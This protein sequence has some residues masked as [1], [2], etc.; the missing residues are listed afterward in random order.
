M[1]GVWLTVGFGQ[2]QTLK[3]LI[4]NETVV[5]TDNVVHVDFGAMAMSQSA[6]QLAA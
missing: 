2:R 4:D 3:H 1:R 6:V 5:E